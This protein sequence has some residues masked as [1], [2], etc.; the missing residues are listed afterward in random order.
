[1][2]FA[3]AALVHD[4]VTAP[5]PEHDERA[6]AGAALEALGALFDVTATDGARYE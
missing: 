5:V 1:M 4:L 3:E 2:R 6:E